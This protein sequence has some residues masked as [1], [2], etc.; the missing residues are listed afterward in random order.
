VSEIEIESTV[1][2]YLEVE[3]IASNVE[4]VG[5]QEDGPVEVK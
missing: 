5:D 2:Q 3:D 1:V 4:V